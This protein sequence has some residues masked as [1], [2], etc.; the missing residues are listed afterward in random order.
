MAT[1]VFLCALNAS[2]KSCNKLQ[3][4]GQVRTDAE[5]LTFQVQSLINQNVFKLRGAASRSER[6]LAVR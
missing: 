5:N 6:L 1:G 4:L 3:R 2:L